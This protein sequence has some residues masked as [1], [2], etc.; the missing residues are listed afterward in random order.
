MTKRF[1]HRRAAAALLTGLVVACA[2]ASPQRGTPATGSAAAL[3]VVNP[4]QIPW[5]PAP[6]QPEAQGLFPYGDPAAGPHMQRWKFP[7]GVTTPVHTHPYDEFV[8]VLGGSLM[9]GQ[10][11]RVDVARE[12]AITATGYVVIPA[13]VPHW[14]RSEA[15]VEFLVYAPAARNVRVISPAAGE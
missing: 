15:P 4:G 11:D 6:L 7:A 8:T 2:G 14:A 5:K 1:K 9:V 13:G 10:G 12:H 3:T